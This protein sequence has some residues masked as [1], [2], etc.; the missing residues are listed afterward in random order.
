[1]SISGEGGLEVVVYFT[2]LLLKSKKET[3][4]HEVLWINLKTITLHERN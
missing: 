3:H 1:M 4:T 2:V